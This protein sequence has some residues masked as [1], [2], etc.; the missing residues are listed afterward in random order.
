MIQH[1][2]IALNCYKPDSLLNTQDKV[3]DIHSQFLLGI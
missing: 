2:Y 3:T 1:S